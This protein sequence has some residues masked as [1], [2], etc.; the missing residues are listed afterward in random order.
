M[1]AVEAVGPVG[2][3]KPRRPVLA[4]QPREAVF[5]IQP[6]RAVLAVQALLTAKVISLP[7]NAASAPKVANSRYK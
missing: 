4:V 5:A 2:P 1:V 3:R 6:R 7:R